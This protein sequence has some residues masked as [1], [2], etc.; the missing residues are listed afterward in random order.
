MRIVYAIGR[1]LLDWARSL[2]DSDLSR[3]N[4]SCLALSQ[5]KSSTHVRS[6]F[7]KPA[8]PA[9]RGDDD[10]LGAFSVG[11][12]AQAGLPVRLIAPRLPV[13]AALRRV[14]RSNLKLERRPR[15]RLKALLASPPDTVTVLG[16]V[17]GGA[18]GDPPDAA[19]AA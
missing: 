11:A 7:Q 16:I 1:Q 8:P 19:A 15:T 6:G 18:E 12:P 10:R 14:T 3:L 2:A 4:S 9:V 17:I 13:P 5:R